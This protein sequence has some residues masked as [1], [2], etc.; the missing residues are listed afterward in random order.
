[1]CVTILTLAGAIEHQESR[2]YVK[3]NCSEFT[4]IFICFQK[5]WLMQ[6]RKPNIKIR[7][8]YRENALNP[9]YIWNTSDWLLKYGVIGFFSFRVK[10]KLYCAQCTCVKLHKIRVMD[11]CKTLFYVLRAI[12]SIT[13]VVYLSR[14]SCSSLGK[15]SCLTEILIFDIKVDF[16]I[17]FAF[18]V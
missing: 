6:H 12:F 15:C 11:C 18:F 2:R 8:Q 14:F 13:C 16:S 4:L 9:S 7:F 17:L 3:A 5:L 1:M 10:Q